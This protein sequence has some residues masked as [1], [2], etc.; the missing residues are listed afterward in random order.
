MP[1]TGATLAEWLDAHPLPARLV[2]S[3]EEIEE[4]IRQA[5]E[6]WD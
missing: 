1:L 4:Q 3:S 6:S 2:R 5:R